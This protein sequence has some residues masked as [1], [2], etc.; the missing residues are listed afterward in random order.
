MFGA[1]MALILGTITCLGTLSAGEAPKRPAGREGQRT[2]P[3]AFILEHRQDLDLS[4][5]QVQKLEALQ[6]KVKEAFEK[7]R[8]DP[9]FREHFKEI[10][11]ARRAGDEE[12]ARK[13]REEFR[14][15]AKGKMGGGQERLKEELQGILTPEQLR[16]LKDL[17]PEHGAGPKDGPPRGE[18]RRGPQPGQQAPV[19]F[20]ENKEK[21]PVK[22]SF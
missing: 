2:G 5:D 14:E 1:K 21:A 18:K 3:L 22:V 4:T 11:A 6:K 10:L 9:Q 8:D 15:Q 7:L 17:R 19:P 12:K 16:K 20:E 13:L